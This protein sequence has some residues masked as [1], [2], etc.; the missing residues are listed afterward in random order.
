MGKLIKNILLVLLA[1]A[2]IFPLVGCNSKQNSANN[3]DKAFTKPPTVAEVKKVNLPE[4]AYPLYVNEQKHLILALVSVDS[5][6]SSILFGKD[7]SH[8]NKIMEIDY[9]AAKLF[10]DPLNE[11]KMYLLGF[12]VANKTNA[13]YFSKDA[14]NNWNRIDAPANFSTVGFSYDGFV[15]FAGPGEKM[16]C[17]IYKSDDNQHFTEVYEAELNHD[18]MSLT[19]NPDNQKIIWT[20]GDLG[21]FISK[22]AGKTF[23]NLN[24]SDRA[25]TDGALDPYNYNVVYVG[26]G[27]YGLFKVKDDGTVQGVYTSKQPT[28]RF[29]SVLT[30]FTHKIT[31][32]LDDNGTVFVILKGNVYKLGTSLN[33]APLGLSE[34]GENNLYVQYDGYYYRIELNTPS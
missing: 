31:Y 12:G 3:S 15:Y 7:A 8:L 30:D 14:G 11:D 28:E 23:K 6:K 1:C 27:N 5:Q 29:I 2:C 4:N 13:V 21:I 26:L 32:A 18:I 24:V 20:F 33:S 19:F 22:D 16:P 9:P 10:A 25:L 34:D 17:Y